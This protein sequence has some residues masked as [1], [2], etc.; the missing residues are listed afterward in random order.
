MRHHA[1][2][3]VANEIPPVSHGFPYSWLHETVNM[4]HPRSMM[5]LPV[6]RMS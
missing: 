1:H 3:E 2:K 4:I 5:I 6:Q